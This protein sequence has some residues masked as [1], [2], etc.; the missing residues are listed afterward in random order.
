MAGNFQGKT[1]YIIKPEGIKNTE[2]IKKIIKKNGLRIIDSK[3]AVLTP[4]IIKFIYPD[5]ETDLLEAHFKFMSKEISEVGVIV[6]LN[7]IAKL[8]EISGKDTNPNLCALGTIRNRFGEKLGYKV[9]NALYYKNVFHRS[10]NKQ[11]A[12]KEVDL[13]DK[14]KSIAHDK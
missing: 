2:L 6:G 3:R 14:I 11:E 8:V 13:F 5:I 1:F 12:K 7:A 10:K 9:G 4:E